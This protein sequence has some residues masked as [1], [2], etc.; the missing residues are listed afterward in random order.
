MVFWQHLLTIITYD[1]SSASI[2]LCAWKKTEY[3]N[4]YYLS[5]FTNADDCISTQINLYLSLTFWVIE[6]DL[7]PAHMLLA[8]DPLMLSQCMV[9]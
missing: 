7:L 5:T 4:I 3:D 1:C 9:T 8:Y 6:I 2:L